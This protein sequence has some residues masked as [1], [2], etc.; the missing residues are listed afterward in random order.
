MPLLL[1]S[2]L[3]IAG[4][5]CGPTGTLHGVPTDLRQPPAFQLGIQCQ[6]TVT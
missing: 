1:L 6:E 5:Q 3:V 4:C 2:L